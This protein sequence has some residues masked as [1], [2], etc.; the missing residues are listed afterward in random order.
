MA[1]GTDS[2]IDFFGTEDEV[3]VA[4]PGAVNAA[5]FSA[6]ADVV[7]WT[8]DDD[9]PFAMFKLKMT[10]AGLSAAPGAGEVVN[11]YCQ[12]LDVEGTEDTPTPD[13][14]YPRTYL[15]TFTADAVDANQVHLIGPIRLPNYE[16]S[17]V[18]EFYIENLMT[19][20]IGSSGWEL[21]ITPMTYGPHA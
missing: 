2:T 11:L 13:S 15:G 1:I 19:P 10:A 7:D 14:N 20:N 5:A 3:T 21:W 17:Q 16:T 12:H 18:Y 8:N 4:S 9:A 6:T